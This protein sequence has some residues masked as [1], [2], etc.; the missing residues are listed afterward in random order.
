MDDAL[1]NAQ[2]EVPPDDIDEVTA[3][4][5][6]F[7]EFNDARNAGDRGEAARIARQFL[8]C[9]WRTPPLAGPAFAMRLFLERADESKREKDGHDNVAVLSKC[10]SGEWHY[11]L[12]TETLAE[13]ERLKS[14]GWSVCPDDREVIEKAK[15]RCREHE[16]ARKREE[17]WRQLCT[18]LADAVRRSDASAIIRIMSA[19]EFRY[20][21][22]SDDTLIW[23]A[24]R[25]VQARGS[26]TMRKLILP[27]VVGI[28]AFTALL[29]YISQ[30]TH[31]RDFAQRRGEEAAKLDALTKMFNPIEQIATELDYLRAE[32]PDLLTDPHIAS[33]VRRLEEMR[34]DNL[35]RTNEIVSLLVDL[36]SVVAAGWKTADK[37]TIIKIERVESL[38]EQHDVTYITRLTQIKDAALE[39]SRS[40]KE[41]GDAQ[42][43]E[44]AARLI[45]ILNSLA[46]RLDSELETGE[47]E[48]LTEKCLEALVKWDKEYA[49]TAKEPDARLS[50][51][52]EKFNAALTRQHEL[53]K[54]LANFKASLRAM[55]VV[56]FREALRENFSRYAPVASLAPLPYGEA[57][58][59]ELLGNLSK[60]LVVNDGAESRN[61]GLY[62]AFTAGK[63][64]FDPLGKAYERDPSSIVPHVA[65]GA[66][67]DSPLY[68]LR[69]EDGK[70]VLR[71]ALVMKNGKWAIVSRVVRDGLLLGE[72]LFQVR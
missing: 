10:L 58:V 26:R 42:S 7:A 59:R 49:K 31:E 35:A 8:T 22:P 9:K 29:L 39:Y 55:D 69:V 46:T 12:A 68:I 62:R 71:R 11:T 50:E 4:R 65:K 72:P 25:I 70:L 56:S 1:Q 27:I 20:R 23:K 44:Y 54:A 34:R 28:A 43:R 30:R 2:P 5:L 57:E 21:E 48:L 40:T 37:N 13:I 45:P 41:R 36:E 52:R 53:Q 51:A 19:K 24:E 66:M 16:R 33:Y 15:S 67:R 14:E 6:L 47:L 61:V 3:Q 17:K 60:R 64:Q 38:L 32:E 18:D 63:I